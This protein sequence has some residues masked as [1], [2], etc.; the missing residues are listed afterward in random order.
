L[1]ASLKPASGHHQ[2]NWKANGLLTEPVLE[3]LDI[4]EQEQILLSDSQRFFVGF[5]LL[6]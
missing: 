4:S 1:F 3:A 2:L 5:R 6:G